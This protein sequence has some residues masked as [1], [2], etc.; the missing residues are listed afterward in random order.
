[1][2]TQSATPAVARASGGRGA[3]RRFL[4]VAP[5]LPFFLYVALFLLFPTVLVV[6]GA[7]QTQSGS[8]TLHNLSVLNSSAVRS[9]TLWSISLS[10][11][12]A[13]SGAVVGG[14]LAY[15]IA[16]S[17]PN[18]VLRRVVVAVC[19]VLAQFGGVLLAFAFVAVI[20]RSG[21]VT[22][23][24]KWVTGD[25]IDTTWL[26]DFKGLVLV[27]AYFQIPLMVIVFLPA[28]DG[29]RP[30]WRE[31]AESLGGS[32][33]VYW[34]S[35]A[36]PILLPAFISS[37]LLLFANSFSAYATAAA[38]ISQQDPLLATQIRGALTNEVSVDNTNKAQV[39]ALLMVV[40]V[41][42]VMVLYSRL[43]KRASR[44]LA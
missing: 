31:A 9:A 28:L 36:G 16:T 13:V 8:L 34:R 22:A 23:L 35:V 17:N 2:T 40:I 19:S 18:G 14:L 12:S 24:I 7:F 32:T 41:T 43:S 10:L 6:V 33:W 21:M 29:I 11:I 27:Y 15:A 44:W 20:G 26:Y 4:V 25:V 37:T 3:R 5:T 38:L 39:L 42:I 1:M 30:Q